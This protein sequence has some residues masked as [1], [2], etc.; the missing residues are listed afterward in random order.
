M[1]LAADATEPAEIGQ[2]APEWDLQHWT[3]AKP[4]KLSDLRGKVVLI[5]WWTAPDCRYCAN[6]APALNEFHR[7]YAKRGLQII[8]AY[9]HKSGEPLDRRQVERAAKKFGFRFPVAIDPDWR[10]I[11]RWWLDHHD[12]RFT[13]MTFLIDRNGVLRYVHPG[14]EY[15]KGQS[16]YREIKDKIEQL[17]DVSH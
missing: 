5:R 8:G 7:E 13:S 10:T 12:A 15:A 6:T 14:G 16:D 3:N 17:L 4:L 1:A 2:P 11:N 9:H